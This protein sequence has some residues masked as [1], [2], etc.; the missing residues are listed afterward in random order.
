MLGAAPTRY[1]AV[2]MDIQMP[3]MNGYQAAEAIR[4]MG[5]AE[6]PIIAMTANVMEDDRARAFEAG[7]NGHVSKPIDIDQLVA[8][9]LRVTGRSA[10]G[11]AQI[12]TPAPMQE[13]APLPAII[14]GIDL[15]STLPRFGGNFA[16]FV[17][18]FKRFE[19]SQGSTLTEV[20]QLLREGE[21]EGAQQ[22]V[23]R[24]R[25]V[26]ANLGATDFAA[27]A[28]DFEQALRQG[29]MADL[30]ARLDLLEQELH[31]LLAAARRLHAPAP[32]QAP[33]APLD[34]AQ[35]D[36]RLAALRDLLQNNNLKALAEFDALRG[37]LAQLVAP[38][39]L[40]AL[41]EA[42]ATLAFANAAQ[43]VKDILD[44]KES[45]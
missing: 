30:I 45:P 12:D 2:L 20:R 42:I 28:L 14:P 27:L 18:L 29:S 31:K 9:L 21:R 32:P 33:R 44:H 24:L 34:S 35:T 41:A 15:R 11:A 39:A 26:A 5:L 37:D 43:Q 1:D 16:N 10:T 25:G 19:Q 23:H 17:A 3:V 6:L 4:A 36:A 7:M 13:E 8:A 40:A 38:D 22:L